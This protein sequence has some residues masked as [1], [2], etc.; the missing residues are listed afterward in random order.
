MGSFSMAV[1]AL[2]KGSLPQQDRQWALRETVYV[3]KLPSEKQVL[4]FPPCKVAVPRA[5]VVTLACPFTLSSGPLCVAYF[6]I[7]YDD[8][9][10]LPGSGKV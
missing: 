4:M 1:A 10:S 9:L 8:L 3:S 7:T 2:V 6:T 5:G